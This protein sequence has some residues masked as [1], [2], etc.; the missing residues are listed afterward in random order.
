MAIG[1]RLYPDRRPLRPCEREWVTQAWPSTE[2]RARHLTL[3][4]KINQSRVTISG[5]ETID[6]ATLARH[7][8]GCSVMTLLAVTLGPALEDQ[9]RHWRT[10]GDLWRALVLDAAG[11]EG[12]EAG[13]A[14]MAGQLEREIRL[15]GQFPTRR[16]SP[17]YGDFALSCQELFLHYLALAEWGLT[18]TPAWLW[19][20]EKT[21]TA[22][23][24]WRKHEALS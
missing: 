23:I 21:V 22:V 3:P 11:S 8:H 12:V 1:R 6:S 17:G 10:E 2:P 19:I 18:L 7:L 16:Y 20:P 4:V 15:H 5:G 24:G 13:I 9:G 14:L